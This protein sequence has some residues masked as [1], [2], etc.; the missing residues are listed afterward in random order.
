MKTL[1]TVI[2]FLTL[3]GL[4]T[5]VMTLVVSPSPVHAARATTFIAL[6]NAG[7]E[8]PPGTGT[9]AGIAYL[10]LGSDDKLCVSFTFGGLTGTLAAAHVHGP[11][12]PGVNADI[13]FPLPTANPI[14]TCVGPL[15]KAQKKDLRKGLL[16]LNVHSSVAP[17]G[18]I[19]GQIEPIQK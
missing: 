13:L 5:L 6:V 18:E 3:A 4:T 19:R 8:V 17:G 14:N 15:D 9:G 10:T 16:Y 11:A 2:R 7:Q 1:L 12:T